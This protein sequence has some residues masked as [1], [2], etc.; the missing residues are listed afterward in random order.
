MKQMSTTIV[1]KF[2]TGVTLKYLRLISQIR[3]F[4]NFSWPSRHLSWLSFQLGWYVFAWRAVSKASSYRF[5]IITLCTH[6]VSKIIRT[7]ICQRFELTNIFRVCHFIPLILQINTLC[8]S[9]VRPP[10]IRGAY[11]RYLYGSR[12]YLLYE[13]RDLIMLRHATPRLAS[14][15]CRPAC[16]TSPLR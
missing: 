6:V 15:S 14:P 12:R 11:A 5:N 1:R 2:R 13:P 9:I 4:T 16:G 10:Y 7:C 8:T 3:T